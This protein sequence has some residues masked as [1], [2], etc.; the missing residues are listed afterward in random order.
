M[1]SS[2]KPGS[3]TAAAPNESATQTQTPVEES[4]KPV[5]PAASADA[6]LLHA[7]NGEAQ[8]IALTIQNLQNNA[9]VA[10]GGMDSEQ[11]NGAQANNAVGGVR[12]KNKDK[13]APRTG[14]K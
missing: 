3:A 8:G 5:D 4:Q 12:D 7:M 14:L 11:E 1:V 6:R 2:V 9:E 10:V 13:H